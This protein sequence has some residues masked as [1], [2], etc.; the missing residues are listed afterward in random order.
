MAG[1]KSLTDV[2]KV[3]NEF[4]QKL[5]EK[6][7]VVNPRFLEGRNPY[8]SIM[9]EGHLHVT[10]PP[11]EEKERG[12]I[13]ALLNQVGYV[14][15]LQIL[16]DINKIISFTDS[17]K[18]HSLKNVKRRPNTETFFAGIVGLGCNIGI[19]KMAQIS[20]GINE[21]TLSTAINW[22]FNQNVIHEANECILEIINKLSLPNTFIE[23]KNQSHSS[24]DGSKINVSVESLLASASFKYHGNTKGV[25]A[26]MFIDERQVLFHSLVLSSV[27]REAAYVIDGLNNHKVEKSAIHSTDTHGYSEIIFAITHFMSVAFAP[28]IKNIGKQTIYAFST[29]KTYEKRGFKVLPSRTINQ[30]III[31]HWDDILRFMATIKLKE[32]T[33]SQLLKRLSSYA[34]DN[35]LY[36][37][38]KEFGR[39]IKSLFILTYYDDVKLRQRV[40]KQLNRIELSNKFSNA[41]FYANNREF[42]QA[43]REEQETAIGCKL[44]IQNAI[45]LW[46][47]LYLSQLLVNCIDDKERSDMVEMIRKG[48]II[49]WRH[50]NLYGEFDFRKYAAN[51][52]YFDIG[53]ILSLKVA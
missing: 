48:S 3:L 41:V 43:T 7:R 46:N 20:M 42:K 37:A 33:A 47:Y 5:D 13:S 45:V 18:H 30:K 49:T 15:V 8:S 22:Y 39:T 6:Y 4:R 29:R 12:F 26:Y 51:D 1:L 31:K 19:P 2:N 9:P 40:E 25:S 24:S 14:P 34:R 28:R 36:K 27:E 32:A 23:E 50:I 44:L 11:I 16:H 21:N 38:L 53:K 10:T 52:R 35:P 17:F